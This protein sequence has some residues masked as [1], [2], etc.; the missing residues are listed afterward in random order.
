MQIIELSQRRYLDEECSYCK[1]DTKDKKDLKTEDTGKGKKGKKGTVTVSSKVKATTST[2]KKIEPKAKPKYVSMKEKKAKIAAEKKEK[3]ELDAKR[4]AISMGNFIAPKPT[5]SL[6]EPK[7]DAELQAE[8]MLT[9]IT[10][11]QRLPEVMIFTFIL[12]DLGADVPE[13][14][15]KSRIPLKFKLPELP[16]GSE[17][18]IAC[19]EIEYELFGICAIDK[20]F[21]YKAIVKRPGDDKE[22][23]EFHAD[24]DE[25]VKKVPLSYV[26][27]A[28]PHVLFYQRKGIVDDHEGIVIPSSKESSS[29]EESESD[30]EEK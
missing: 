23:T 26:E 20:H 19:L 30:D 3:A 6:P 18:Y 22:W 24:V 7:T 1:D 27:V 16:K 28:K 13:Y 2:I 17:D 5:V 8:N 25:E 10:F 15:H 29:E 12:A 11:F 9:E 14:L 21:S 4:K